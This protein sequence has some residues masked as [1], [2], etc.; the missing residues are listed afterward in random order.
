MIVGGYGVGKTALLQRHL[1]GIFTE[2]YKTTLGVRIE[3]H[4]SDIHPDLK[5]SFW[6][7]AG[8]VNQSETPSTYFLGTQHIL[9]IIDIARPSTYRKI[10]EQL[11][12]LYNFVPA[13]PITII[14]NKA[15]LINELNEDQIELIED[16][17]DWLTSA[18]TGENIEELFT[19]IING[20]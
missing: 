16:L 2:N 6:D 20:E 7:T 9:Y 5:I 14:G 8:V 3:A 4:D 19:E 11:D 17:C 12:Y 1:H 18:R 10:E 13:V 15:D